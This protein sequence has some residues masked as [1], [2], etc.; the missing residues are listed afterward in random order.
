MSHIDVPPLKKPRSDYRPNYRFTTTAPSSTTA[1]AALPT[2]IVNKR[3]GGVTSNNNNNNNPVQDALQAAMQ[4]NADVGVF[5]GGLDDKQ[6]QK[7]RKRMMM[8]KKQR[9]DD[10]VPVRQEI[11]VGRPDQAKKMLKRSFNDDDDDDDDDGEWGPPHKSKKPRPISEPMVVDLTI[12]TDDDD[13]YQPPRNKISSSRTVA[14]SQQAKPKKIKVKPPPPPPNPTK[15]PPPQ[16]PPISKK[17]V[18]MM[19][20]RS[21]LKS[22]SSSSSSNKKFIHAKYDAEKDVVMLCL[23]DIRPVPLEI[24]T[25]NTRFLRQSVL[26]L[27]NGDVN[28]NARCVRQNGYGSR[29]ACLSNLSFSALSPE[30]EEEDVS[31]GGVIR[32]FAAAAEEEWV[33]RE[34]IE[35]LSDDSDVLKENLPQENVPPFAS[36]TTPL[37]KN[38]QHQKKPRGPPIIKRNQ[39][40]NQPIDSTFKVPLAPR[41]ITETTIENRKTQYPRKKGREQ[42]PQPQQQGDEEEQRK[43]H[44]EKDTTIPPVQ[45]SPWTVKGAVEPSSLNDSFESDYFNNGPMMPSAKALG[46]RRAMSPIIQTTSSPSSYGLFNAFID[47]PTPSTTAVQE[48]GSSIKNTFS[49]S[50]SSYDPLDTLTSLYDQAAASSIHIGT[51]DLDSSRHTS[52]DS[53]HVLA[54]DSQQQQQPGSR[55]E[56]FFS[57]DFLNDDVGFSPGVDDH[58]HHHQQQQQQQHN[59]EDTTGGAWSSSSLVVAGNQPEDQIY[60]YETI[61]PTL[62]GGGE[63]SSFGDDEMMMGMEAADDQKEGRIEEV[64]VGLSNNDDEEDE[65]S[66]ANSLHSFVYPPPP[67]SETYTKKGEEKEQEKAVSSSLS[68]LLYERKLPPRNRVKRVL[69]DMVSHEDF[70]LMVKRKKAAKK[71]TTTTK[72]KTKTMNVVNNTRLSVSSTTTNSAPYHGDG[73]AADRSS[74]DVMMLTRK[75][76]VVKKTK[77]RLSVSSTNYSALDGDDGGADSSSSSSDSDSDDDVDDEEESDGYDEDEDEKKKKKKRVA[78]VT[79][80]KP[81]SISQPRVSLKDPIERSVSPPPKVDKK[82]TA[83]ASSRKQEWPLDEHEAYCHQCRNKTYY[84]KMTCADCE[85]KFCVRCYALRYAPFLPLPLPPFFFLFLVVLES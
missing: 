5:S 80:R 63:A 46:K 64:D 13:Y 18:P 35:I 57:S 32:E 31:V 4:N 30:E 14:L 40:R 33:E 84:A 3:R 75:K 66:S 39:P 53:S 6:K 65:S 45:I 25:L 67:P 52:D 48:A 73:D 70:D 76:T 59:Y 49:L 24:L 38:Q 58:H 77:T 62:L 29:R 11:V 26:L 2:I 83:A 79:V 8:M 85:K 47:D 51:G 23:E 17:I 42:P 27:G 37:V 9:R 21:L 10:G 74:S 34:V 78:A 7:K 20:R 54:F 16:L 81:I 15:P 60:A 55:G 43:Q 71:T 56:S 41:A 50:T 82:L 61:D 72:T 28:A 44:S 12:S 36:T 19:P 22:S 69:P 1:A 68:S